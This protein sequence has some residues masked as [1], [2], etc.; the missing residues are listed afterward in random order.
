M[1][2]A[3]FDSIS[4]AVPPDP[5]WSSSRPGLL[6]EVEVESKF[7]AGAVSD[8]AASAAAQHDAAFAAAAA[9]GRVLPSL[10]HSETPSIDDS[11]RQSFKECTSRALHGSSP[12]GLC[13][14]S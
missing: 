5:P 1:D 13:L 10:E 9:R 6:H 3:V 2:S 8:G 7:A 4:G 12:T 11:S 14:R